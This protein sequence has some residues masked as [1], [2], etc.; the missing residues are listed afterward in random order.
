MQTNLKALS[1][2]NISNRFSRIYFRTWHFVDGKVE[3]S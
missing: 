3:G 1:L 2:Y